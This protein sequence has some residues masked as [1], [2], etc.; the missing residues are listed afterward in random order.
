PTHCGATEGCGVDGGSDGEACLA[1]FVCNSGTCQKF[2]PPGFVNCGGECLDPDTNRAFCGATPGCGADGEGSDGDVC[3]VGYV[4]NQGACALSCASGL[5]VCGGECVD[6]D[7]D[8][9]HCGATE[10]CG[11]DG[12]GS[13][14]SVCGPG[15]VCA[16]GVCSLSCPDGLIRCGD[17]CINPDTDRSHC[18][19]AEG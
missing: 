5:V 11:Q 6:R 14:G 1:G 15:E 3:D 18:G 12:Q 17:T 9:T 7:M 16:D 13:A 2:C 19:A 8:R 4:C 10:G